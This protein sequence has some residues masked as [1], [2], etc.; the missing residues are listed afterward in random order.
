MIVIDANVRNALVQ[1]LEQAIIKKEGKKDKI[2][3]FDETIDLI[4]NV[5]DVDIKNPNNRIDSEILLPHP[6]PGNLTKKDVCFIVKDQMELDL[7]ENGYK[8][9]NAD[10]LKELQKKSKKDQK[11][12]A[13]RFKYFVAR[14]DLMRDLARVLARYLGQQGKMP[15]P[16]PKGF[17]VI[18]PNENLDDY[19]EKMGRIIKISMKKHLLMQLKIGKKSQSEDELMENIN[20][21]LHFIEGELPVGYNNVRSIY[22]K[23]TMGKPVMVLEAKKGGRR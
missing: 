10:D 7:K 9:L 1:A 6:I 2:R 22:I 16:Q 14:A 20:S 4:I 12:M 21:V 3:N 8:V 13:K 15:R 23:T 18:R 5:R 19:I 11:Q 17:G